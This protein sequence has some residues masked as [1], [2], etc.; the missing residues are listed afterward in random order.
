MHV[1]SGEKPAEARALPLSTKYDNFVY[2]A[3][4]TTQQRD[5]IACS[6]RIPQSIKLYAVEEAEL[7]PINSIA[8]DFQPSYIFWLPRMEVFLVFANY[9]SNKGAAIFVN[10]H[11]HR[12]L[13]LELDRAITATSSCIL[14]K[15]ENDHTEKVIIF[16]NIKKTLLQLELS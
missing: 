9:E 14:H 8:L 12:L 1:I 7:Q 15:T 11:E 6:F 2:F 13:T 10:D 4:V 16:D 3:A 5:V